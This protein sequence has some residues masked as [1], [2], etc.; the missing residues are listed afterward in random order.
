[1]NDHNPAADFLSRRQQH[2][3]IG[4]FVNPAAVIQAQKT[5]RKALEFMLAQTVIQKG[6]NRVFFAVQVAGFLSLIIV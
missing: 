4:P 3:P 6:K 5:F 1:M 2:G